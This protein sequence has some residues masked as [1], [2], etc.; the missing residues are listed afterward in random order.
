MAK[1]TGPLF[2]LTAR[3]K[4]ANSLVYMNWKGIDDVRQYVVPANPKTAGQQQQRGYFTDGVT[5]WHTAGYTADDVAAYDLAALAEKLPMSGFNIHEKYYVDAVVAGKTW[6]PLTSVA[7][8]SITA[9]GASVAV[10]VSA[11]KTGKLY[12]GTSKSTMNTAVAGTFTTDHYDFALSGLSA[13]TKYYF[14]IQNEE[15]SS[16]GKTGIYTFTTL[17]S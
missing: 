11:D 2:S 9:S 17:A 7:V 8:S 3:G 16:A 13:S 15:A 14:Y 4:L 10:D 5:D 6:Y 12:F 1:V